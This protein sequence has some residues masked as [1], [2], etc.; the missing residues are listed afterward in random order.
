MLKAT[1][2]RT[3]TV[4]VMYLVLGLLR[5]LQVLAAGSKETRRDEVRLLDLYLVMCI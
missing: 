4:V 3:G 5:R 1:R 2:D